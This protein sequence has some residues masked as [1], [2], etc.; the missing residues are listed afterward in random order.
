[1]RTQDVT[2]VVL[3]GGAGTRLG[4]EDKT[5]V[6]LG[7]PAPRGPYR[8]CADAAGR[9]ADR[10]AAVATRGRIGRWATEVVADAHPGEG[11]LGGIV[12]AL[13]AVASD[14]ILVH[15][16]DTPFPHHA[17]V[18]R[19]GPLADARGLAVARTGDQRQHLV[20]LLSRDMA[21][22]LATFYEAG[23][24]AVRAWLDEVRAETVDMS[25]VAASFFNVNTPDD[26]AEA[27]RRLALRSAEDV[28]GRGP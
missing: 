10:R 2:A 11:P 12:S 9:E 24:R 14:W 4:A 6:T 20:Q 15:P 18:A 27:E 3:C 8:G 28:G 22:G 13:A 23:G 25:D 19:L 1:M 26:L 16:G 21:H 17:L 7:G 5:L